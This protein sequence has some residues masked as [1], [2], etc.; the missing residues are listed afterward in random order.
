MSGGRKRPSG[1]GSNS[2]RFASITNPDGTATSVPAARDACTYVCIEEGGEWPRAAT[3]VLLYDAVWMAEGKTFRIKEMR[4]GRGMGST[5]TMR[6]ID[7]AEEM[8][9]HEGK[10]AQVKRWVLCR[11]VESPEQ[12]DSYTADDLLDGV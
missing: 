11:E 5:K 12:V 3:A 6:V 1:L 4:P 2:R 8:E 7:S 9:L 10:Y